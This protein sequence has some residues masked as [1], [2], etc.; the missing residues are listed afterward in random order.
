MRTTVR[1]AWRG[2]TVFAFGAT[3]AL[4]VTLSRPVPVPAALTVTHQPIAVVCAARA[5]HPRCD[6]AHPAVHAAPMTGKCARPGHPRHRHG[7]GPAARQ[8]AEAPARPR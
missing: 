5:G 4:A 1:L 8:H 3:A 2:A 7:N 6:R